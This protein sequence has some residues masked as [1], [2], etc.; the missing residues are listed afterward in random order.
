M[1]AAA[2]RHL[3]TESLGESDGTGRAR[4]ETAD[5]PEA[6]SL[7][8]FADR[9]RRWLLV[10]IPLLYLAA[11]NGQWRVNP[12]S[13]LYASLGKSLALG[14]GYTYQGERHTWVEPGLPWIISL[15]FRVGGVGVF[16]PAMLV[17]LGF[18]LLALWLFYRLMV[19][20]AGRPVAVVLVALLALNETFFRYPL[21][22]FTEPPF[23]VGVLMFLLGYESIY[24]GRPGRAWI[25][26]PLIAGGTLLMTAM[27]PVV[28]VFLGALAVAA[29]WHAV[30]GPR[31]WQHLAI[32]ALA[33][34][35][36][37]AFR[38]VDPRRARVADKSVVENQ[39]QDLVV[40][41]TGM[42]IR[43]SLT[44][45]VPQ[46]FN[47]TAASAIFG[48]KLGPGITALVAAA[49]IAASLLLLRHRPLWVIYIA[50]TL[51]QMI[52]HLPRERYFLPVL[53]LIL[54]AL[55]RGA[56]L[57]NARLPRPGARLAFAAVIALL[58]VL[59]VPMITAEIVTQRR[60][61]FLERYED[62]RYAQLIRLGDAMKSTTDQR[63]VVIAA[64]DRAITYFTG[65]RGLPGVKR[66]WD[67]HPHEVEQYR[68]KLEAA[69]EVFVVL[70]GDRVEDT[71]QR[72]SLEL[73]P[74]IVT[75]GRWTLHRAQL[76]P[77][78]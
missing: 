28:W 76:P 64:E 4:P 29:L 74:P 3:E 78:K 56:M 45:L 1:D 10:L 12:D 66:R 21:F 17:L 47:E 36:F 44:Q 67:P 32:V 73:S 63:D 39:M 77:S 22:L 40:N 75:E 8:A 20:H 23:L 24:Q 27:R 9:H 61:P 52:V 70:P 35:C 16:W 46:L 38:L 53:P 51:A 37:F 60:R 11:F 2:R 71:V 57:L 13:A 43:R 58:L 49:M 55:W 31:R 41:R 54:Y 18:A 42:M 33:F 7:L 15:G 59:N 50:A 5:A 68:K 62:G 48:G 30:R 69:D 6:R 25:D 34:G 26:W 72:L 14:E 65:L 19:M